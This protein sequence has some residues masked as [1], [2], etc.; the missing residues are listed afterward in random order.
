MNVNY[1]RAIQIDVYGKSTS[2]IVNNT[3]ALS[4][5]GYELNF[6][7]VLTFTSVEKSTADIFIFNSEDINDTTESILTKSPT[8][9]LL[10]SFPKTTLKNSPMDILK[11]SVGLISENFSLEEIRINIKLGLLRHSE[12]QQFIIRSQ[13][14]D[15]KFNDYHVTG[16]AVGLL[17]K[18]SGLNE[19]KVLD[20]IKLVSRSKQRRI[21]DVSKEIIDLFTEEN[22]DHAAFDLKNWLM[23]ALIHRSN[24]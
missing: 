8:P 24:L 7:P 18:K 9:F 13:N 19:H 5:Y 6:I 15:E 23:S 1:E 21:S 11:D 3:E 12:R 4:E 22:K 17:M 20:E 14:L 16:V 10:Q 2:N